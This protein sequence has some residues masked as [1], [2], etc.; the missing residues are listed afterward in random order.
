[1]SHTPIYISSNISFANRRAC[2]Y[3][4]Y[5][6]GR[7]FPLLAAW[8]VFQKM[9][10]KHTVRVDSLSHRCRHTDTDWHFQGLTGTLLVL[11][12]YGCQMQCNKL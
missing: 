6:L 2:A 10:Q 4:V 9:K 11:Y 12:M 3:A 5:K 7:V 1:M 8:Q